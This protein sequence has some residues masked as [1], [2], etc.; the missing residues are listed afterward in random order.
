MPEDEGTWAEG[1]SH[2][3]C[4]A[5]INDAPSSATAAS[6]TACV[7]EKAHVLM[8]ASAEPGI[9]CEVCSLVNGC[10]SELEEPAISALE[11]SSCHACSHHN[12]EPLQIEWHMP[13]TF[14]IGSARCHTSGL[15]TV[16]QLFDIVVLQ[17]C[18][19]L[20]ATH[21]RKHAQPSPYSLKACP[22]AASSISPGSNERRGGAAAWKACP[23][24][25]RSSLSWQL[26]PD[27]LA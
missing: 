14:M 22:A 19:I 6:L 1:E 17:A 23:P 8:E 5:P 13:K 16:C 25:S 24:V 3:G 4:T 15:P 12:D 9:A 18:A 11:V 21:G 2:C 7:L 26:A 20:F 27:C 10:E